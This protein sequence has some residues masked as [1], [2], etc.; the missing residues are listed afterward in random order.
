MPVPPTDPNSPPADTPE[1][2]EYGFTPE[3]RVEFDAGL[4]RIV[5]STLQSSMSQTKAAM[6]K[7]YEEPEADEDDDEPL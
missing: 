6:E 2:D 5:A 7:M 3:E 4:E 1:I